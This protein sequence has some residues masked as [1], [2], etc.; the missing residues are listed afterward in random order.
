MTFHEL[1]LDPKLL[2]AIDELGFTQCTPVQEQTF[3]YSLIGA[4]VAVQSQTG[5][6]KTAAFLIS[7]FQLFLEQRS[8]DDCMA[9]IVAPT[10][11]LA[12]QIESDALQLGKHLDL[13]IAS[14]YGGV[15]YHK[16]ERALREGVRVAI[17]TPGRLLD[18]AEQR[19][20]DLRKVGI[21]VIDEA[22][23]MFDMGFIPDLRRLI[24]QMPGRDERVTMLYSATLSTRVKTLA[25]DYMRNPAEIT[26]TPE[27]VTVDEISQELYHVARER[28]FSLL[29]GLLARDQ[30]ENALIFTNTKQAA[31][32][33]ATRMQ[34]NGLGCEYII[35]D[36]PQSK[37][38]SLIDQLKAGELRYLVA[39]DVAAR[40]LHIAELDLVVNYELPEHS[41]NY[42]HRIGR[43]ARAGRSGKAVALACEEWVFALQ[44]IEEFIRNPIPVSKVTDDVYVEDITGGAR[45]G[46][47]SGGR[48]RDDRRR[49]GSGYGMER[50]GSG[51]GSSDR[52]RRTP[53]MVG[54]GAGRSGPPRRTR[55]DDAPAATGERTPAAARDRSDGARAQ[56]NG[57]GAPLG[58]DAG[59]PRE[60]GAGRGP[61]SSGSRGGRS[62]SRSR[63][64]R[65]RGTSRAVAGAGGPEGAVS[66]ANGAAANGGARSSGRAAGGDR[67]TGGRES[68]STA[69]RR[70]GGDRAPG[71]GRQ[72]DG[73]GGRRSR[74]SE[75]RLAY[76]REKYGED[77]KVVSEPASA[78][79]SRTKS[80]PA[81]AR[82]AE[83]ARQ[84]QAGRNPVAGAKSEAARKPEPAREPAPA[85]TGGFLSRLL[86]RSRRSRKS[87]G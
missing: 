75:E 14:F 15:G 74:S 70:G 31:F 47:Y 38:Q 12:D 84:S 8:L 11:E 16:Q 13:P 64:G 73:N 7:I 40:G 80:A 21:L 41:E 26:I 20:L 81:A 35:G 49:S 1:D 68:D 62:R 79:R 85:E 77:F 39:T 22:D 63:G 23:R 78:A 53:E 87:N 33:V 34:R 4:D 25:F 58:A 72:T 45:L 66:G 27:R 2:Q 6:G 67:T 46:H 48:G 30:P 32:E 82:T 36:L 57:S 24:R 56:H 3:V 52:G 37:R 5:T 10:R 55:S 9:L 50:R 86:G 28:K 69:A 42:V 29:L 51:R 59:T 44:G 65:G 19:K 71:A 61:E 43:T 54:A 18:F 83:P 17:G 60:S 76:Y